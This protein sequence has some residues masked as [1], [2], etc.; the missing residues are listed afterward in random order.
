MFDKD[1]LQKA[2]EYAKAAMLRLE[3]LGLPPTPKNFGLMYAY[4]SGR[5]PEIKSV[6]DEAVRKGG[7]SEGQAEAMYDRHL[8]AGQ[9]REAIDKNM[10]AIND[11]LA[12]VMQMVTSAN[13]GTTQFTETLSTFNA[14]MSKPMSV[15]QIRATVSKVVQ[16][17]KQIAQQ[18]QQLQKKLE[19]SSQQLNVMKED[20]T[21]AQKES[22]TDP[23]TGVGNRKHFSNELKRLV[24]EADE[25]K[26]PL[27]LL[28]I[29]IDYFKK[30]NDAHGHQVGDQVLKL[31]GRT[32]TENLKGRDIVCRYGG[33][34][35]VVLLSQTRI[36]DAIRVADAL[37]QFVAGKKI[38][39]RD[40]NQSL[41]TVTISVGIAQY[42]NHESLSQ[43]LRRADMG[44]YQAKAAGRNRV[45][46]QEYDPG[47]AEATPAGAD[48]FSEL[49]SDEPLPTPEAAHEEGLA[50]H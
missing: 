24:K 28:M 29:D 42:H 48:R 47:S 15:E 32:M 14:D 41:G 26:T 21:K 50:A 11:E 37:R 19:H 10:R 25:A 39:R 16:E 22:L 7:L 44:V 34:E 23:L 33:E 13:Q 46:V 40:T 2:N 45:M 4:A 9:E 1:T 6:M 49:D 27:S 31:V 17:T 20:L 12:K 36:T 35:F 5:L 43:F 18:N 38:I 8:G 3:Y 30:F